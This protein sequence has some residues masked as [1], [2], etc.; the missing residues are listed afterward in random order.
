MSVKAATTVSIT[1]V[2]ASLRRS[3]M[4][5]IPLLPPGPPGRSALTRR[6]LRLYVACD[7]VLLEG[8]DGAG[9]LFPRRHQVPNPEDQR[10][11]NR[12]R[13]VVDQAGVEPVIPRQAGRRV[14][15]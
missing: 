4:E 2:S 7:L 15:Q 5:S 12:D 9:V 6:S 8:A 10:D 13:R 14:R 1:P 11:Q 3:S